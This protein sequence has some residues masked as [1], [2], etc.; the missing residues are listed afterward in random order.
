LCLLQNQLL[1]DAAVLVQQEQKEVDP[2]AAPTAIVII[3]GFEAFNIQLYR[4]AAATVNAASP[5]TPVKIF[6]DVDITEN[7]AALEEA[8]STADVVLCSLL[9][10]F[11]EIQWLLPRIARVPSRF[12]FESSLELMSETTVGAFKMAGSDGKMSGGPPA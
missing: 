12:C 10:D 11:N 4:K 1:T 9:F 7:P 5:S 6:T 2:N 8:L 3:A